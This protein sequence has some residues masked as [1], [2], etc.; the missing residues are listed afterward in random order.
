MLWPSKAFLIVI[1]GL[2]FFQA[3]AYCGLRK[4]NYD[5]DREKQMEE[6]RKE[7]DRLQA[8][9]LRDEARDKLEKQHEAI[10]KNY[11]EQYLQRHP[12]VFYN[13]RIM[14]RYGMKD[15]K[16]VRFTPIEGKVSDILDEKRIF[17]CIPVPQTGATGGKTSTQV[18]AVLE[19]AQAFSKGDQF[20][21]PN[22]I[23]AGTY[24]DSKQDGTP[25]SVKMY[26]Q[27]PGITLKEFL[28]LKKDGY[29]FPEETS[30]PDRK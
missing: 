18:L 22:L 5:K 12:T 8:Q 21:I 29:T 11:H 23:E 24:A 10:R 30:D 6:Q 19:K 20:S 25:I 4:S 15:G 16:P 2:I 26:R 14:G 9:K 7:A 17:V 28:Q 1:T 3:T 27:S 13:A